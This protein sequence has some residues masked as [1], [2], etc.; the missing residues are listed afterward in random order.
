MLY[1]CRNSLLIYDIAMAKKKSKKKDSGKKEAKE[2]KLKEK[3]LKK[4]AAGKKKKDGKKESKKKVAKEK[5]AKEK[6]RTEAVVPADHSTNYNARD[7]ATR[8]KELKTLEEVAAF[9]RGETR[10]TVTRVIQA[11][12][13]RLSAS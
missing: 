13:N 11:L 9:A 12:K 1:L 8:L 3:V 10:V 6:E 5:V 2:K 4:K 7:A